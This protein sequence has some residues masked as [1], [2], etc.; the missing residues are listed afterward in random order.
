MKTLRLVAILG[1][2]AASTAPGIALAQMSSTTTTGGAMGGMMKP[3][4][5]QVQTAL[6]ATHPS[7]RQMKAI[8]PMVETYKS[9]VA[10]ATTDDDKKAAGKQLMTSM[11]TVLTPAQQATFKQSLVSQMMSEH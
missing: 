10:M 8:K 6:K 9:Q 1:L 7:L 3:T 4:K 5:E 2:L 11:N